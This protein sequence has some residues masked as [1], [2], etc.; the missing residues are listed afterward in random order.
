MVPVQGPVVASKNPRGIEDGSRPNSTLYSKMLTLKNI[1][2]LCPNLL[3]TFLWF[4][5][6]LLW[7]RLREEE[8]GKI[9]N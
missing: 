6:T 3:A 2:Y 5:N 8:G 4:P 9:G 1:N 7:I